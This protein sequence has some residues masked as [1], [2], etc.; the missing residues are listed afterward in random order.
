MAKFKTGAAIQKWRIKNG[1]KVREWHA[2]ISWADESGKRHFKVQKP[3]ENTKTAAKKLAREML[4]DR[5]SQGEQI[6]DPSK[7]TFNQLADY[8]EKT[9]VIEPQYVDGRKVAG[10]RSKYE[11]ELRLKVLMN[12]FGSRKIKQITYGDL[13]RYKT[14]RFN[15]PVVFGKN[16]RGTDKLGNPTT[17]QRS[18]GTVHKELS[19]LRR[20]LNVAV[21]NG[22]ILKNPF[23]MGD[24]LINPG[25]EKARER[26]LTREEEERLLAACTGV[27]DHLRPIIIMALDT[28]MRRGEMFKLKWTDINFE[29]GIINIQAFNTKTLRQ[30]QVAITSRLAQELQALW[31]SSTLNPE[32][33]VFGVAN[34]KKAF[35]KARTVAGASDLRFHDLRHTNATRLVAAH[36]PLSEV[37]RVLGHTQA[38][39]TY[40]YVNANV[41]TAR[42]AAA[43]LDQFHKAVDEIEKPM[44]N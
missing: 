44:V 25:D 42:R 35:S 12:H 33:L 15:T 37:G 9:Y 1:K 39:T 16:T 19:L 5:E 40:R 13:E 31:G 32:G 21:Q 6:I 8:F 41:D 11:F 43:A 28:G 18:I 26:I 30:R 3:D 14:I 17:R 10:L 23:A 7:V 29:N 4:A 24:P 34:V 27:R 38:N 36:I 20:V 2:C 22:W